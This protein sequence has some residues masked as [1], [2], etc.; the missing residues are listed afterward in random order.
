MYL[1]QLV[2]ASFCML[3]NKKNRKELDRLRG[4]LIKSIVGLN[5]RYRTSPLLNALNINSISNVIDFNNV[6]LL[7]NVMNNVINN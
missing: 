7:N 5:S 1:M 3:T 4:K 6:C 2:T